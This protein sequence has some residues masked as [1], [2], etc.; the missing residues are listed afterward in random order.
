MI[1][2]LI[3]NPWWWLGLA[4]LLGIGE[5]LTPGVF[6]IWIGAA[7]AITGALAMLI[8]VPIALQFLIFAILC[9]TAV[10]VGRRWYADNPV[11]SQDPHLND[12]TARL[13]GEIATLAEPV[14]N[15]R[16]RVRIGDGVW[17]CSGPDMDAGAAVRITGAQGTLLM[18]EPA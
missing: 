10:W 2:H 15:G 13:I 17:D 11:A 14:K 3:E 7:A 5:I 16:G 9:L 1:E 6:L 4:V 12:R 18:V 8:P